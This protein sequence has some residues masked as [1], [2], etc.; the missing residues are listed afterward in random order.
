MTSTTG[1]YEQRL[2][3]LRTQIDQAKQEKARAEA[4]LQMVEQR[5]AEIYSELAQLGVK[6]EDLDAEI[7][8]IRER[9]EEELGKA[10]AIVATAQ[11]GGAK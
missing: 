4:T 7:K 5:R 9:L 10:E 1:N 3:T 8:S 6:P 2:S 11:G